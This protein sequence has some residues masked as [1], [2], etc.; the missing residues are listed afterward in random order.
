MASPTN[1]EHTNLPASTEDGKEE[2]EELIQ[3]PEASETLL[4]I[5]DLLE[6]VE[7]YNPVIPDAVTE[8]ILTSA[9]CDAASPDVTRLISLA[10]QKFIS[11]LSYETLQH[12]KMRGGGKEQKTKG[13]GRDRKYAMATEDLVVALADQGLTVKKPPY[14]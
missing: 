10:A 12:C 9:G 13:A 6:K 4:Q 3:S 14:H 5:E 7:N 11:D 8:S 2:K 1:L